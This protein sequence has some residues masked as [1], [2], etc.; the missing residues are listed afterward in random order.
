M[1]DKAL[2]I[3]LSNLG[4]AVMTTAVLQALHEKAP[5][6]RFDIV[7]D[8]RSEEIFSYCPYRDEIIL[9]DK[10]AGWWGAVKL[11]RRLRRERYALIVD[12]RTDG[13][14]YLLRAE[15]RYTKW[16][17]KPAAGPHAVQRH[18]AIIEA[19]TG[20]VIPCCKVWLPAA[21][22]TK[23]H[24]KI[25]TARYLALAPGAKWPGKCWPL[26]SYRALLERSADLF[27]R[28]VLLGDAEDCELAGELA[29]HFDER[30]L[31]LT[32]ETGILEAAAILAGARAFIGN[33]SGLGH[34]GAAVGVPTLT[35]FGPGEPERYHPWGPLARWI[36]GPGNSL[37]ALDAASVLKRLRTLLDDAEN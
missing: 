3:S 30:C 14:A 20:K 6:L 24:A 5:Q 4:D 34:L 9:R 22:E 21:L 15:Q 10:S 27:D 35:V 8:R 25:A 12:L 18:M 36:C 37:Q 26:S 17:A 19:F 13:L 16:Q 33:D 7:A 31:D 2:L 32:G 11:I 1:S 29:K 23:V 28:V